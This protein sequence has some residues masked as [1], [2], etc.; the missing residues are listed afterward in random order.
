MPGLPLLLLA[1][2]VI[3]GGCKTSPSMPSPSSPSQSSPPPAGQD[4]SSSSS[5][6]N[7]GQTASSSDGQQQSQPASGQ[8]GSTQQS[9]GDDSQA[10]SMEGATGEQQQASGETGEG[11]QSPE[12]AASGQ[13]EDQV[14]SEA[15]EVFDEGMRRQQEQGDAAPQ[16]DSGT[17]PILGRDQSRG[18]AGE[19]TGARSGPGQTAQRSGDGVGDEHSTQE[20]AG[21]A[22]RTGYGTGETEQTAAYEGGD[23]GSHSSGSG[24]S[25]TD[26]EK[27]EELDREL[28]RELARFDGIILERRSRATEQD[29]RE[30]TGGAR[31]RTAGSAGGGRYP[32]DE[33]GDSAPLLTATAEDSGNVVTRGRQPDMPGDQRE[34]DYK[35]GDTPQDRD[36]RIPDD[37]PSGDD[38]DIVARQLREAAMEEEDPELREKLWDEYRKYKE[39]V[40]AKR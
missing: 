30:G 31:R 6:S 28:N 19:T 22:E 39:G 23:G 25:R 15:M 33:G 32:G 35:R 24:G 9:G 12:D 26:A 18:D 1:G 20:T 40:Q 16:A 21:G 10:S 4:G 2:A 38:D 27:M 29:N 13:S 11:Q 5:E 8:S 3:L 36:D 14:L 7:G 17:A 34:G 37:I